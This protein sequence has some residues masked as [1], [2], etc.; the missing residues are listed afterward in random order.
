MFELMF[1][2][3]FYFVFGGLLRVLDCL[4]FCLFL[5]CLFFSKFVDARWIC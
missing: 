3:V 1:L 2:Y 5:I 4:V